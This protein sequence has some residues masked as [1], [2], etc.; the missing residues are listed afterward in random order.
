M[1]EMELEDVSYSLENEQQFWAGELHGFLLQSSLFTLLES[2]QLANRNACASIELEN[3]LSEKCDTHALIDNVLRA[4][5][6]FSAQF[7]GNEC[8]IARRIQSTLSPK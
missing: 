2:C 8:Q 3:I 5:L 7:K 4:Y 6:G 1:Q